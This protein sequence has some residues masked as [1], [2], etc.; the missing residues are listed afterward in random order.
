MSEQNPSTPASCSE[1]RETISLLAVGA[2][3]PD[4]AIVLKRHLADCK[5]C[6]ASYQE[7][8]RVLESVKREAEPDRPLDTQRV[9]ARLRERLSDA[10]GEEQGRG[11]ERPGALLASVLLLVILVVTLLILA[12]PQKPVPP[13]DL[14]EGADSILFYDIREPGG[15]RLK[16]GDVVKGIER[17]TRLRIGS[18]EVRLKPGSE[19]RVMEKGIELLRGAVAVNQPAG[20]PF[21][22]SV[23]AA[24]AT[25]TVETETRMAVELDASQVCVTV[26]EGQADVEHAGGKTGLSAGQQARFNMTGLVDGPV[27]VDPRGAFAWLTAE[28]YEGL[29]LELSVLRP[30]RVVLDLRNTSDRPISVTGYHP[31]GVNYQLEILRPGVASPEF[32]KLA[33]SALRLQRAPDIIETVRETMGQILIEPGESFELEMDLGGLLAGPGTYRV[34]AEYLGFGPTGGSAADLGLLLRS[35]E[36]QIVNRPGPPAKGAQP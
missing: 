11:R 26:A 32:V 35:N 8:C 14:P 17:S 19:V 36:V 5:A 25:I 12:R 16:Q 18:V 30:A 28:L 31:L 7:H 1:F 13:A 2:L 21:K 24:G 4:E 6:A 33:P 3:G 10:T 9:L 27:K 29:K 22:V 23:P 20:A 15:R 34:A